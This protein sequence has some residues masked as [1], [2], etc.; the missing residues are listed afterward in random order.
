VGRLE[1]SGPPPDER[2]AGL[3]STLF[4]FTVFLFFILFATQVMVALYARSTVTAVSYDAARR[5]ASGTPETDAEARAARQM[6]RRCP[7]G[8]CS[9]D[10]SRSDADDVVLDVDVPPGPSL[11]PAVV[12]RPMGIDHVHRSFVVRR[13]VQ[14]R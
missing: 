14:F 1:P 12:R 8:R 4:G 3:F 6:G 5:V 13:E 9:F 10:W 2:G 7:P 11:I